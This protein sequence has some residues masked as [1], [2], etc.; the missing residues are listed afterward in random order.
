LVSISAT[1]QR[2]YS[3]RGVSWKKGK[4]ERKQEVGKRGFERL[5]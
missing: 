5:S 3:P 4:R 1:A 2:T